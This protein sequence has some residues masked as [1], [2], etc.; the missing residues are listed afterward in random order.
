M[1]DDALLYGEMAKAKNPADWVVVG[2]PQSYEIYGCMVRKDDDGFKKV[3][4]DAIA[5]TRLRRDQQD[6]HK[7]FTSR[8]RP[9]A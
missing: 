1:M 4:D 2:K 3:V 6:L 9:R 8:S 7:W 5:A